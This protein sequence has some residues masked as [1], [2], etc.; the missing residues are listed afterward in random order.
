MYELLTPEEMGRADRLTMDTGVRDGFSLMLAA[1]RA[2]AEVAL[3]MFAGAGPVAVLCGPG[4]NG[5]DGYVAAQYLLEAGRDVVCFASG[6]PKQGTDAMR[7]LLFY[8]G[9]V[10]GLSEFSPASFIGAIDAIYGAGLGRAVSGTEAIAIDALNASDIPVVA[11]DLPSGISGESG[12]ALGEA[13]QARATVT[14][15]RKKPGH[16][17]QPGRAHC[18]VLHVADIGIPDRVLDEI[19]PRCFENAPE[20]WIESLPSPSVDVHKYSR[21]HAAVFSGGS[22]STGAAR[23][24]ALAAARSGAG[25]VTLLSPPDAL[26]VNAAHVTSIMVRET[27]GAADAAQFVS[28]RKVAAA[29]LG[30]GYGDPASA[31]ENVLMLLGA[32]EGRAGHLK[33]LVLDADGITAFENAPDRLFDSGRH[34]NLSLVLTPHEGEFRRLFP[35]I[36]DRDD[37]SKVSKAREAA[38]LAKAVIIYKGPDS[39]IAEP[40]GMA[41]INA[42]GTPFL[43]TAGSGDVLTGIICGLLS[44]GMPVF[45]AAC[46]AVWIHA[47]AARR[48]GHGLIAEDLPGQLPAVWSGLAR[49]RGF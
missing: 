42:N 20:M 12:K 9:D 7:A 8:K 11:V 31:Q 32:A 14:F 40:G 6:Q 22:H 33:G 36:A 1:G 34:E 4:N 30:P 24:S 27:R 35:A 21:G 44:Q 23:L 45:E 43:A 47:D 18:G 25:A 41:A 26:A 16:L 38:R 29:V 19:A 49:M 37:L 17:L 15:F 3:R 13:V 2:V 48:F 10:R 5:G 28:E 39:V 46:S